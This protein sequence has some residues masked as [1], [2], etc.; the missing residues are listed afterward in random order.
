MIAKLMNRWT[1][2]R[3]TADNLETNL[4]DVQTKMRRLFDTVFAA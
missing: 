1:G 2:Q 3:A 4:A